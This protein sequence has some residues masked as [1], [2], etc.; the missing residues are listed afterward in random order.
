MMHSRLWPLVSALAV[1][2]VGAISVE[3]AA[4]DHRAQ[5]YEI[6]VSQN[7]DDAETEEEELWFAAKPLNESHAAARRWAQRGEYDRALEVLKQLTLEEPDN[8]TVLAEYGHWLRRAGQHD[9]A[10]DVLQSALDRS[11]NGATLH[12]DMA[13]VLKSLGQP[14]AAL[15]HFE[16]ALALRPQHTPT[17]I[18]IGDML[19]M[20][21]RLEEAVEVLKPATRQGSN[22]ERARAL[23]AIGKAYFSVGNRESAV[24]ALEEA[25]ERAPASA[26]IWT[27]VADALVLSAD[28]NDL[29]SA[30]QHALRASTLAPNSSF[31]RRVLA[32]AYDRSNMP[33]EAIRAY[34]EAVALDP[35]DTYARRFLIRA[36]LDREDYSLARRHSEALLRMEPKW[37]ESH[38]LAGL[39]EFRAGAYPKAHAHYLDALRNS[40]T[41][42]AEAWYNLGL[43]ARRTGKP[44]EAVAAYTKALQARPAY[45]AAW[46]NLGLVYMDTGDYAKAEASFRKAIELDPSYIGAWTNLGDG[47][48]RQERY[49]DAIRAYQTSLSLAPNRVASRLKLAIVLRKIGQIEKAIEV[50]ERLVADEPRYVRAWYNLGVALAASNRFDESER[51]YRT[52]LSI[53]PNH[54]RSLKNLGLL[55]ARR[56]KWVV[57]EPRLTEALERKPDDIELRTRLAEL[58]LEHGDIQACRYQASL[59]LK[60][61]QRDAPLQRSLARC[62][63]D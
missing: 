13:Q 51:A 52:A 54:F 33:V 8:E 37:R 59:V 7:S 24:K 21:G 49:T 15:E 10:L 57:A 36:A 30:I 62:V 17:R 9:A 20:R 58:L 16:K 46:N 4:N 61:S 35:E 32:R 53:D 19:R 25:V 18:E 63:S 44:Q 14:E 12:L 22:E 38:F 31:A 40:K 60:Q 45:L 50:Y 34:R 26:Q 43:L 23:A 2:L 56:G 11:P 28:P 5:V 6:D 1:L 48:S 27:R 47:F 42:Y 55:E 39:V 3:I 29:K 41:P